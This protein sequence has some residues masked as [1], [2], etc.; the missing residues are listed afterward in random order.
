M[1]FQKLFGPPDIEKLK[2]QNDIVGLIKALGYKKDAGIQHSAADSLRKMGKS[3]VKPLEAAL[4]YKERDVRLAVAKLLGEIG[5]PGSST[6]LYTVSNEEPDPAV[7]CAE[8]E[9]LG[10]FED[11]ASRF[12]LQTILWYGKTPDMRAAASAA[13]VK[14]GP[15]SVQVLINSLER[16]D[17]VTRYFAASALGKI[18]D[19]QSVEPLIRTLVDADAPTRMA[20][21][22]ALGEIGDPGAVEP[23]IGVLKDPHPKVR[24]Q[25]AHALVKIGAP[26]LE[27]LEITL[28]DK[29]D[30]VRKAAAEVLKKIKD[31]VGTDK[32][33][34][35]D[36]KTSKQE[37]VVADEDPIKLELKSV[38]PGLT[39]IQ[40]EV[41]SKARQQIINFTSPP[42][43]LMFS[44]TL[45]DTADYA[46]IMVRQTENFIRSCKGITD[47]KHAF[48]ITSMPVRQVLEIQY[49]QFWD[50]GSS[51]I[52]NENVARFGEDQFEVFG[53][54]KSAARMAAVWKK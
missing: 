7:R 30:E 8:I 52:Y 6:R 35:K 48:L 44:G 10:K 21:A 54:Q 11:S 37:G 19:L 33:K 50:D 49:E 39:V 46:A 31:Q 43:P 38:L 25:S 53:S 26:A 20:A 14:I 32:D 51:S 36:G 23:L 2:T 28:E 40:K 3:A 29:D 4:K 22:E 45:E 34:T 24:E 15:P 47:V 42:H 1:P 5:D 16:Q 9:A 18:G 27:A 13:M 12:S 17:P 41:I